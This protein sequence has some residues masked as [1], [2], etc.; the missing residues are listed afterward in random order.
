MSGLTYARRRALLA[1]NVPRTGRQGMTTQID[2]VRSAFP[3]GWRIVVIGNTERYVSIGQHA[4]NVWR[5]PAGM[6][7][8]KAVSAVLRKERQEGAKP[9]CVRREIRR[10]LKKN[11][12]DL[13]A[14]DR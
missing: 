10:Q 9:A 1:S 13:V 4:K 12:P 8:F 6:T 14:K 7:E 3:R 11:R 2:E 5:I